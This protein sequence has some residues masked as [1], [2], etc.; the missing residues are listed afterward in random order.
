MNVVERVERLKLNWRCKLSAEAA[1]KPD[2]AG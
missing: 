2:P 1:I